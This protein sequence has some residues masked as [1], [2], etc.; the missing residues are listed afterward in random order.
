MKMNSS[1]KKNF[2]Y[3]ALY[4]VLVLVLPLITIPYVSRI[5]GAEK[6]GIY[7]YTNTIAQYFVIFAMLGLNNY[8]NRAIA[9]ARDKQ[10]ELNRVF[11]E[12]Y[13]M[14]IV[15]GMLSLAAYLFYAIVIES[16]Y[17]LYSMLLTM[18]VL[19]AVFD[20]NWLFFGLEKFK[21]TVTR[22][23]IIKI[24][25]VIAILLLVKTENDLW[26]YTSIYAVSM[27]LS[28][29]ALWPY[30]KKEI[31]Y[32]IPKVKDVWK[33]VKPNMVMFVPV[34]A[35]SVYKY[36]D[37]LMLGMFSK[38]ET[39]YYENVE[40]IM[41]VALGFITAFG[42]VMLPRMSNLVARKDVSGIRQTIASSMRFVLGMS[43]ALTFGMIAV[44]PDFVGLYF[45]K[46]FEPCVAIMIAMAPTM[47]FQSWANVVRTQY[48]IPFK[49]DNIYV[50]SVLF[51]AVINFIIN[52][53]LIPQI[54][55]LGAVVGTIVA[56][57]SVAV[58][59]TVAVRKEL[60][61]KL[62]FKQGIPFVVF[63]F[64]MYLL[65]QA[66]SKLEISA[67]A[68]VCLEVL[69]GA[70]LYLILWG[71]YEIVIQGKQLFKVKKLP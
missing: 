16:D 49:Y 27:L 66:I 8:G 14:Q 62:Y 63:G 6:L 25:S 26:I 34:V 52:Y 3:S 61:V 54:G 7:S 5:F 24:G 19:S 1:A 59:Q 31:K 2:I 23:S 36:M 46:G 12:I 29:I 32:S 40:K 43:F 39:G 65:V 22:N 41:T 55:A 71:T 30:A 17:K 11:S 56:E 64:A 33:H 58:I 4:Q 68:T 44:A 15:T 53:L 42:N 20:I 47:I 67:M 60:D 13:T 38:T 9:I 57:C 70:L 21:L 35:I 69:L 45:G 50:V 37:K 51:G 28:T 48:L 10:E 18:Y